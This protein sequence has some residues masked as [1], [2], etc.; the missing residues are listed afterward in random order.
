VSPGAALR[1]GAVTAVVVVAFGVGIGAC[2]GGDTQGRKGA[3]L[4]EV[5]NDVSQ[6]RLEV[7]TL[8]QEIATLR[9]SIGATPTT[10]PEGTM[11]STTTGTRPTTTTTR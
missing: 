2:G 5:K 6:L 7:E 9:D 10:A 3:D 1:R 11:P 8:R 4:E